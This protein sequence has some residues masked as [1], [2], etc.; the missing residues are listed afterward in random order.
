VKSN[1]SFMADDL[2]VRLPATPESAAGCKTT[3][4]KVCRD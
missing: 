1:A 2:S 4:C 3:L